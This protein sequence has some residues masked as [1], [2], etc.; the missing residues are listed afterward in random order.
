MKHSSLHQ[1]SLIH[2]ENLCLAAGFLCPQLF[3]FR[4]QKPGSV[5]G[6]AGGRKQGLCVFRLMCVCLSVSHF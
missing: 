2:R 4:S 3:P 5:A 6:E 1:R